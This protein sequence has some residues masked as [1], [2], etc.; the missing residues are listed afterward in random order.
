MNWRRAMPAAVMG[1]AL[2]FLI[3]FYGVRS[4]R[5]DHPES[6]RKTESPSREESKRPG[7]ALVPAKSIPTPTPKQRLTEWRRDFRPSPSPV[8]ADL[9]SEHRIELETRTVDTSGGPGPLPTSGQQPTARGTFPWIVQFD[10][11]VLEEWKESVARAGGVLRGYLPNYA[12]VVEMDELAA[13]RVAALPNVRWMDEYRPEYKIQPFLEHLASQP[14]G[15][16]APLSITVQTF[17]PEDASEVARALTAAGADVKSVSPGRRWGLVRASVHL[18]RDVLDSLARLGSVQWIE[19]YVPPA[20]HN[21]F[22]VRGNHLNVTNV[23]SA[24]G[25]TGRKQIIGHADT[26]LDTGSVTNLHPDLSGRLK[27]V[28]ALGRPGDWSDTHGHGTHTAGSILGDGS[29]STGQFRGVAYEASLV[30]QSVMDAGGG[31]GGIPDALG[32]LFLQAYTNGARIHSDSWGSPVYGQYTSDSQAADEFM[33]D[34]PDML[35]VFSAGNDGTD[36]NRNGVV[37]PDSMGAPGTAKNMLTVGAAENDRAAGSGGYS[38]FTWG[39]GWPGDY[40]VNPIRD[41]YI[42]ESADGVHQGIAAFSSRGPTD[43]GRLKPDI[44]GPGTDVISCRSHA[45]GAESGWGDHPNPDY[46]FSGG[47]S[48]STPLMAG[49]AALVRQYFLERRGWFQPSAALVKATLLN[50]ARSLTPGQYGTNAFRE[51]PGW[52]RPNNVEGWGQA[53]LEPTLFPAPPASL[54]FHDVL[55]LATG[56]TNLYRLFLSTNGTA[57]FTLGWTDYP[58]TAGSGKKLVNDLDLLVLSPSGTNFFPNGRASTDRTNNI[59]GVDFR[60][61]V[62]GVYTAR[63]S[64]FNVPSGPQN[65]ALV[66]SGPW[67]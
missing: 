48:M 41:D 29:A 34:Y 3:I 49:A 5:P 44:V 7:R 28:Y 58:G 59:E 36:A 35:L 21:D 27:A 10:G 53:D 33:W 63:V 11:P 12:F 39:Y 8:K 14:E 57:R 6:S 20:W 50:G 22:A 37:D 47:T 54:L 23:W 64:G 55:A 61:P 51:V 18:T 17:A 56:G 52:P 46:A 16:E 1:V 13:G 19:E 25:L 62:S 2:V 9:P 38:S 42:S 26:G 24:R 65:F 32:D 30:H 60:P 15:L 45:P 4:L 31:L 40:A 67:S 43:D 66:F